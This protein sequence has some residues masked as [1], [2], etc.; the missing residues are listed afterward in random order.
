MKITKELIEKSE[1]YALVRN[2]RSEV[3]SQIFIV[4]KADGKEVAYTCS[5][6]KPVWQTKDI[7]NLYDM[8]EGIML[9]VFTIPTKEEILTYLEKWGV[10]EESID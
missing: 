2:A 6:N 4:F 5:E 9:T 7:F 8:M 10:P 3:L 1:K